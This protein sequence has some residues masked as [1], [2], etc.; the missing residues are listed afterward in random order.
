MQFVQL[1]PM[2]VLGGCLGVLALATPAKAEVVAYEFAGVVD[3]VGEIGSGWVLDDS[4]RDGTPFWG[5]FTF[6]P[7]APDSEPIPGRARYGGA[8]FSLAIEI[9]SYSWA[10]SD[11]GAYGVVGVG[12]F[13]FGAEDFSAN[14]HLW[15][16]SLTCSLTVPELSGGALPA[17]PFPL[18]GNSFAGK[19]DDVPF[20]GESH[21]GGH[22]TEFIIVP[23]PTAILL[24]PIAF[25]LL[26]R[27]PTFQS[28]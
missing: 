21:I 28:F 12:G 2:K 20:S 15:V 10:S 1:A 4:V 24:I 6:D 23:E 13:W 25:G 5:R 11:G 14:E 3:W 17:E 9:G 7:D 8:G 19:I 16:G 26:R 27:R 22:L 18:L